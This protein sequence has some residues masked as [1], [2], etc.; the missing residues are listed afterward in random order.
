MQ[1]CT[2][3]EWQVYTVVQKHFKGKDGVILFLFNAFT[4]LFYLMFLRGE[5]HV[6]TKIKL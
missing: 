6:V 4:L 5:T 2:S 1:P 3:A